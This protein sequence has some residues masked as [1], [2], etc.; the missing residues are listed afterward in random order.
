MLRDKLAYPVELV[1]P[2]FDADPRV[3]GLAASYVSVAGSGPNLFGPPPIEARPLLFKALHHQ[4]AGVRRSVVTA[5]RYCGAEPKI[6]LPELKKALQDTDIAVRG[7]AATAIWNMTK[8]ADLVIPTYAALAGSDE[9]LK[10]REE[11]ALRN[12]LQVSLWIGIEGR[13]REKPDEVCRELIRA[14][15][16]PSENVR[17][18]AGLLLTA[19]LI[20]KDRK[21][22]AKRK[23]VL[24]ELRR[25]A[26][27]PDEQVRM[28]VD[29]VL[30]SSENPRPS[31]KNDQPPGAAPPHQPGG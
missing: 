9:P 8:Q 30:K 10:S 2:L 12:L 28:L 17:K 22:D 31:P 5:I 26:A 16:S 13:V 21:L 18:G 1:E 6:V 25:L 11:E 23:D 4:D 27:D 7:N 24:A 3:R 20:G 15:R 29:R 14:L 19:F